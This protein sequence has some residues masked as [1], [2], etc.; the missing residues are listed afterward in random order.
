MQPRIWELVSS[1]RTPL[2]G[3]LENF[4]EDQWHMWTLSEQWQ[5]RDVV[6]HLTSAGSTG[7]VAW[8][9]NM[10]GSALN[11]DRHNQMLLE[12]YLGDNDQMTLENFRHSQNLRIAPLNSAGALLGELVVHGQDIAVPCAVEYK[13][14][15]NAV[16][17]VAKFFVTKDFAVNS[18]KLVKG[19]KLSSNDQPF[20][21]GH[22]PEIRGQ[23]LDLVMVMA[24]RKDNLARLEG[25]G[26]EILA[27]RLG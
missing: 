11:V 27:A 23:L 1:E 9:V 16:M 5:A 4:T 19:L 22:G 25:A 3:V 18:K 13:P 7:V 8:L 26:T 12:K 17:E 20:V 21:H 6:A 10:F 15:A 24:R 2:L 14:S